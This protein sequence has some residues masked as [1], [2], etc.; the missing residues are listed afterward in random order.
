M[1][2]RYAIYF[3]PAE[4]SPWWR[5][6]C[7]WLGYDARRAAEVSQPAIPG[8]AP[9]DFA[10]I[11]AAPRRYGFHAT[12]KAP[13]RLAAGVDAGALTASLARFAAG[14]ARFTLPRL[15]VVRMGGFLACVMTSRDPELH[16]LADACVR[17][18]DAFRAPPTGAE[19]AK[20]HAGGL[21]AEQSTLLDRWGYPHVFGRFRF[22]MT[23]TGMLD[24]V[25]AATVRDVT[26]AAAAAVDA[27]ADAPLVCDA[28]CLFVQAAPDARFVLMDRFTLGAAA[29]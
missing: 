15:Q 2:A 1:T 16:A 27:L 13:M 11:T 21:D 23:L 24:H 10:A 25:D 6:G 4:D 20:R 26:A 22:H 18:F 3:A 17:E 28:V 12:L 5:F 8:V 7:A 19:L 9:R 29:R 14:R